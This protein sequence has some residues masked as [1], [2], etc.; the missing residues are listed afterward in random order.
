MKAV[1]PSIK[2]IGPELSNFT[3]VPDHAFHALDIHGKDWISE[4]LKSNGDM[5][6]VVTFHRY[7]FP[8]NRNSAPCWPRWTNCVRIRTNGMPAVAGT[9]K[10]DP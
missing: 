5:V 3:G 1:D 8:Q 4:F 7:P 2:L 6:D 10:I 9:T